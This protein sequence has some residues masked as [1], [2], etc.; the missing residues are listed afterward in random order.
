MPTAWTANVEATA[1]RDLQPG[2]MLDCEGGFTVSVK[3][4]PAKA[5]LAMSGLPL[6]LT[7]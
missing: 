1:K 2:D 7:H 6:A 5:P 3:L 4:Q